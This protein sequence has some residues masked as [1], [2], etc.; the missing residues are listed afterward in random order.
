MRNL[1]HLLLT[2][3]ILSTFI[4]VGCKNKSPLSSDSNEQPAHEETRYLDDSGSIT[5]IGANPLD[6]HNLAE[7]NTPNPIKRWKV[8]FNENSEVIS[9]R[10]GMDMFTLGRAMITP[11]EELILISSN[12]LAGDSIRVLKLTHYTDSR[13]IGEMQLITDVN[14]IQEIR[15]FINGNVQEP[16]LDSYATAEN[17][18]EANFRIS[19]YKALYS[20]RDRSS[21][22]NQIR[23]SLS[24]RRTHAYMMVADTMIAED[25][26]VVD[27]NVNILPIRYLHAAKDPLSLSFQQPYAEVWKDS[28]E[29]D[30]VTALMEGLSSSNKDLNPLNMQ[31]H[32]I[33]ESQP[34]TFTFN[35]TLYVFDGAVELQIAVTSDME[36]LHFEVPWSNTMT[37]ILADVRDTSEAAMALPG[38]RS[39]L[40]VAEVTSRVTRKAVRKNI[41]ARLQ[42]QKLASMELAWKGA[43]TALVGGRALSQGKNL[44]AAIAR[45]TLPE[46]NM[47]RPSEQDASRMIF[48]VQTSSQDAMNQLQQHQRN[49]QQNELPILRFA[50]G[51]QMIQPDHC[52]IIFEQEGLTDNFREC[53]RLA[54]ETATSSPITN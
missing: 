48:Q 1:S 42:A 40:H 12:G 18:E 47:D 35:Q 41:A 38:S 10:Y 9:L 49:D 44:S 29:S 51:E 3:I 25:R 19:F 46:V 11:N 16:V 21:L 45:S 33:V 28:L 24:G 22:P 23:T 20:V 5:T 34:I 39:A 2:G 17:S 50:E 52:D 37:S 4:I 15:D 43:N 14:V 54:A 6:V 8:Q 13:L 27:I 31:V 32:K 36:P 53:A 30:N 7:V 26:R